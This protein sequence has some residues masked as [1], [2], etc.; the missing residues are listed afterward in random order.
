MKRDLDNLDLRGAF[1]PMPDECR[2]ALMTA[3]YRNSRDIRQRV[4]DLV[5]TFHPANPAVTVVR[6]AKYEALV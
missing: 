2:N 5:P 1:K 4:A 3:A 6:D